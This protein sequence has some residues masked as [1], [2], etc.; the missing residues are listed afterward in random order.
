MSE[1]KE[2]R[3]LNCANPATHPSGYCSPKCEDWVELDG[4]K[5]KGSDQKHTP[6]MKFDPAQK[7]ITTLNG[8][9]IADLFGLPE[10]IAEF[11]RLFAS[12]PTQA[13]CIAELERDITDQCN[14]FDRV[15]IKNGAKIDTLTAQ[16]ER[17]KGLFRTYYKGLGNARKKA[18]EARAQV[19]RLRGEIDRV[20]T[21]ILKEMSN[22]KD[23]IPPGSLGD[24]LMAGFTACRNG[25][26]HLRDA[27]AET[28]G[29]K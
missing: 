13:A 20:T 16:V 25:A 29:G 10:E 9:I 5:Q 22:V 8:E 3:R 7:A 11:G 4:E 1:K 15:C 6:E 2:C 23:A 27:L 28:K 14:I 17:L 24:Q 18:I 12:A 21:H 19:E 26:N